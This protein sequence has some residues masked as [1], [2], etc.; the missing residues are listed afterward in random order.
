MYCRKCGKEI[1]DGAMYCE[2]CGTTQK[3]KEKKAT[4]HK[5]SNYPKKKSKLWLILTI[6]IL[7]LAIIVGG[8]FVCVN[9]AKKEASGTDTASTSSF[10]MLAPVE[11]DGKYG[12]ISENGNIIIEPQY[13]AV[14]VFAEGV[15]PVVID[16][17]IGFIDKTGTVVI[18]PQF[19]DI[20]GFS[21]GLIAV[22]LNNEWGFINNKGEMVIEPQFENIGD[23]GFS[24]GLAAVS[25]Y[26]EE[27]GC[28]YGFIDKTGY[29]VITPRYDYASEFSNGVAYVR[30]G[31][32]AGLINIQNDF[33]IELNY[34]DVGIF[35]EGVVPV[36]YSEELPCDEWG[37]IDKE[38]NCVIE[39]KFDFAGEFSDGLAVAGHNGK[40][41][42]INKYGEFVVEPEYDYIN[43]FS[44]GLAKV[45]IRWGD[46][47][48]YKYGYIDKPGNVIIE[49]EYDDASDFSNGLAAV[50]VDGEWGYINKSGEMVI[51]PQFDLAGAFS[52]EID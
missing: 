41:G 29:M 24:E 43:E 9:F 35:N 23:N 10:N 39:A 32:K 51:E 6:V 15:A 33:V 34:I 17:K 47:E 16:G 12:Y 26:S 45:S 42:L 37:Y 36:C 21:E 44:D 28:K 13:D 30:V 11:V 38:G 2:Y 49:I 1:N 40:K 8:I 52:S 48:R 31:D 22:E 7:S 14:G 5:S 46:R 25:V 18:E 27:Y 19:E 3:G 50:M 20:E 4:V